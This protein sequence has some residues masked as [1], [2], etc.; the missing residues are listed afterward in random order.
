MLPQKLQADADKLFIGSFAIGLF[1]QQR[2]QQRQ[3]IKRSGICGPWRDEHESRNDRHACACAQ[4]SRE[5]ACDVQ[6]KA[7]K[8]VSWQSLSKKEP[9]IMVFCPQNVKQYFSAGLW[10]TFLKTAKMR[11]APELPE[12]SENF[13]AIHNNKIKT[14]S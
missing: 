2:G 12:N 9:E 1:W 7:D 8:C 10:V 5:Y 13:C 14:I 11:L 3:T 6:P 4:G